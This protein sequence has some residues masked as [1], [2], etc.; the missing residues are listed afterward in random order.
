MG[1]SDPFVGLDDETAGR[2][3]ALARLLAAEPCPPPAS[4]RIT[5]D[6]FER[7][8]DRCREIDGAPLGRL[9][10]DLHAMTSG[11]ANGHRRT[12]ARMMAMQVGRSLVASGMP[13][14]TAARWIEKCAHS[15]WGD[16]PDSMRTDSIV[17]DLRRV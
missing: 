4:A 9:L 8:L 14:K 6:A 13:K 15:A 5:P 3:R 7:L 11:P 12:R 10:S 1:P 17:R 16:V 2:L